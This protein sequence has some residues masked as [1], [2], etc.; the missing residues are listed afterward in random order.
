M[1]IRR[2][3]VC[4]QKPGIMCH[5]IRALRTGYMISSLLIGI[6]FQPKTCTQ[7]TILTYLGKLYEP[8]LLW[9][10][11]VVEE[12][13]EPFLKLVWTGRVCWWVLT[14]L[15]GVAVTTT[16]VVAG[17]CWRGRWKGR[18]CEFQV[19]QRR[20]TF[21]GSCR[22]FGL[23]KDFHKSWFSRVSTANDRYSGKNGQVLFVL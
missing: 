13:V 20:V 11:V 12:A 10:L 16:R 3:V 9:F 19:L 22:E 14:L 17:R 18:Q 1:K 6:K 23:Q 5:Q 2:M 21:E 7:N 15:Q 4:Y 8:C